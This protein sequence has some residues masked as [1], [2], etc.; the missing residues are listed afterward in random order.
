MLFRPVWVRRAVDVPNLPRKPWVTLEL[1]NRLLAHAS[2]R[3]LFCASGRALHL[4]RV[5]VVFVAWLVFPRSRP[6]ALR[7]FPRP[8]RMAQA[9][10]VSPPLLVLGLAVVSAL[11]QRSLMWQL[12]A[13]QTKVVFHIA[14]STRTQCR[15]ACKDWAMTRVG[16]FI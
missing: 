10:R 11:L 5:R 9:T 2:A 1:P 13:W 15:I 14:K 3:R 8:R 4:A 12:S 7:P 16:E 6:R